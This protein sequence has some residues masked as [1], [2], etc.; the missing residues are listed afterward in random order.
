MRTQGRSCPHSSSLCHR[1]NIALGREK[2]ISFFRRGR[3]LRSC[4]RKT[5]LRMSNRAKDRNRLSRFRRYAELLRGE[6]EKMGSTS[7]VPS[8]CIKMQKT[9]VLLK[10]DDSDQCITREGIQE[11]ETMCR[12]QQILFDTGIR[13]LQQLKKSERG[14]E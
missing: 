2:H 14:Q 7:H 1:A 11:V 5:V 3:S 13:A 4:L 12:S 8:S 10:A 6:E 9:H